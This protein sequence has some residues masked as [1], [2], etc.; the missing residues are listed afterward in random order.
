MTSYSAVPSPDVSPPVREGTK[1]FGAFPVWTFVAMA[2]VSIAGAATFV[3]TA[4]ATVVA[5][6]GSTRMRPG[7]LCDTVTRSG[8]V[9][10][11]ETYTEVLASAQRTNQMAQY[12]GLALVVLGVALA[13][14]AFL[15]WRQD[16]ALK[17]QLRDDHGLPISEHSRTTSS[18]LFMLLLGAGMVGAAGYFL[19]TGLARDETM[20]FLLA[21]FFLAA[22]A[23]ALWYGMPRNGKLLQTFADGIRIVSANRVRDLPWSDVQYTITVNRNAVVHNIAGP[24]LKAMPLGGVSDS[25]KLQQVVQTRVS[26]AQLPPALAAI[27]QGNALGFGALTLSREGI[28][29]AKKSVPW[30]EFDGIRSK[31]ATV[32]VNRQ[33]QKKAFSVQMGQVSN[34]PLLVALSEALADQRSTGT[35]TLQ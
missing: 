33:P 3:L 6:C 8:R 17:A 11:T 14:V 13:V 23:V 5:M 2:L 10:G 16:L 31:G 34:Y 18:N 35:S 22:G 12:V 1:K 7:A 20:Q 32:I 19:L 30:P 27:K 24:G 21:A 25:G 4:N 15:R 28:A 9:T 29:T 26:Q